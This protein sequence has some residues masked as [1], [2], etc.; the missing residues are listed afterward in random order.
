MEFGSW[1]RNG[2]YIR[3]V[4]LGEG[5]S[6]GGSETAGQSFAE[7]SLQRVTPSVYVY[8][9]FPNDPA[10]DWPVLLYDVEC[11]RASRPYVRGYLLLQIM[12]NFCAFACMWIPPQVGE[13]MGLAITSLLAAV[14]SELAVS[15]Q[16]PNA[17]ETNWF[18]IFSMTSMMFSVLVVFQSTAVIYFYYYTGSDLRPFY[19]RWIQNQWRYWRTGEKE[20]KPNTDDNKAT[21]QQPANAEDTSSMELT[22]HMN[23]NLTKPNGIHKDNGP[24]STN[25]PHVSF[26]RS[27]SEDERRVSQL[28]MSL[29]SI[30]PTRH[31]AEDFKDAKAR[32]NNLRWQRVSRRIDD[33]S[34][35][36]IPL[37]YFI[38]LAVILAKAGNSNN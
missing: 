19:I 9:P 23:A 34:R 20:E 10:G 1:A 22:E 16:L 30:L 35:L 29:S 26:S 17:E 36:I 7:F 4:L 37:L 18:V 33:Y 6:I 15:E 25:M 27:A 21:Q 14:A 32:Q 3:P 11:S 31:D 2:M 38:F 5:Y 24:N 8:P 13:R 28:G 12:L